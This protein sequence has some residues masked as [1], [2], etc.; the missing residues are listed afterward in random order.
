MKTGAAFVGFLFSAVVGFGVGF[1]VGTSQN[2]PTPEARA[3]AGGTD[4][5]I[6]ADKPAGKKAD[7][8]TDVFKV[9]VGDSYSKG[10]A[11][12][13]VTIVEFSDFQCPFCSRANP[14][15]EKVAQEYGDKVRVV[16]KHQ[17]LPFHK[18]ARLASKYAIAAG[19]QGKFWEMHDKLF[20][21]NKALK[22]SDLKGYASALGLSQS[23]I[24]EY[25]ESG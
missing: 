20:A 23:Q 22:E 3:E 9:P 12:A 2:T 14:T 19:K 1:T 24:E 11:D 5:P 13:L 7:A 21:N 10:P 6:E 25:I 18:D 4:K 17:P 16:F 8:D 15:L